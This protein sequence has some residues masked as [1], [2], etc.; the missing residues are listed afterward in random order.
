MYILFFC[1]FLP[2]FVLYINFRATVI[3]GKF[4]LSKLRSQP[5]IW[6][7][8]TYCL[9]RPPC[10]PL[11]ASLPSGHAFLPPTCLSSHCSC[12]LN[13][14]G[15]CFF[16][17]TL[18]PLLFSCPNFLCDLWGNLSLQNGKMSSALEENQRSSVP[19]KETVFHRVGESAV[20]RK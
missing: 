16:P 9:L 18:C 2:W 6:L 17:K 14:S 19:I 1:L 20:V 4:I 7:S 12:I 15:V 10:L 13:S 5:S 3:F 8:F 11:P